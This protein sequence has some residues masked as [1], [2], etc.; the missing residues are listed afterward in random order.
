MDKGLL[1]RL[2]TSIIIWANM[3]L[4]AAGIQVIPIGEETVYIIVSLIVT[5]IS[6]L[7]CGWKN[8]NFTGAAKEAQEF[9]KEIKLQDKFDNIIHAEEVVF[10]TDDIDIETAD[11]VNEKGV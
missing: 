5:F 9:L 10:D 4:A 2:I 11:E 7:W 1:I 6:F 8:N 3:T